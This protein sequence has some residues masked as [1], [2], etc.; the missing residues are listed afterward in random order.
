[1]AL[2][3]KGSKKVNR[4]L[5]GNIAMVGVLFLCAAAMVLPLVYIAVTAF[6]PM[7]E[8][9]LFPP[10]FVVQNPTLDNF[11]TMFRL[12]SSNQISFWRYVFNTCFI[13][14]A[15]TV[16]TI[17]ISSVAAYPMAKHKFTGRILLYNVV[18]WALLFRGE[19][20]SAPQY[21]IVT[22]L[23]L[24]NT[25][26]AVLLPILAGSMGVFLMRQ[27]MESSIPDSVLEAARIDGAGELRTFWKIAM[28]MVRP[29]W[30][31]LMI[32]TF[33]SVWNTT[34]NQFIY[35]EPMKM[36]PTALNQIVAAGV[37]RAGAAAAVA[38]VQIIPPIILF[39]ISQSSVIE[40][41]STSGLK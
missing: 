28:P 38:L 21:I 35:S 40:T 1:M 3:A 16:L 13:S 14:V 20:T 22:K 31:T 19:V 24:L 6:K 26:W 12:M 27:F 15:G 8:L 25:Y 23:G 10:R 33:Q 2:K 30:L 7:N 17:L 37:S 9:F 11:T 32:F 18:V 36:L 5:G 29:A 4:S 39:V 41:M 34:G